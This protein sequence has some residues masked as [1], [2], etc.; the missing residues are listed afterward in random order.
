MSKK[1]NL[2]F[3]F[4]DQQRF[5]TLACYGNDFIKMPN[6]NKLAEQSYV[7][8]N[9]YVTQ[10]VCTPSR[11]SIMTGL[12]PHT[13]GCVKNNVFM[14]EETRTIA[15]MLD[16]DYISAYM[17][18]WH[19]GNERTP[20]HGFDK[21]VSTEDAYIG[22][23][24]GEP[25]IS[26]NYTKFVTANGFTPDTNEPEGL[27]RLARTTSALL[28]EKFTKAMF[29]AYEAS[30]FIEENKD[31]P[32]CLYLN[33]LEPHTPFFSSTHGMYDPDDLP[34]PDHFMESPDEN[35]ALVKQL[36]SRY[37]MNS[38]LR[39]YDFRQE[40]GWKNARAAYYSL[41][42]L[43]DKSVGEIL[44][45]L[46]DCGLEENTIV[47]FTSDH[48]CMQGDHAVA[49]KTLMYE[50]CEKVPM[51]I[52]VP[53]LN[54]E[55]KRLQGSMSQVDLVPT[56]L[57]LMGQVVPEYLEGDSLKPVLEGEKDLFDN[58]VFIEWNG[59]NGRQFLNAGKKGTHALGD[60]EDEAD[61]VKKILGDISMEEAEKIAAGPWRSIISSD[62]WK[63]NLSC[64]DKCE[65]FDLNNDPAELKNLY[66]EPEQ[67]ER[68]AELR[69]RI[70]KWQ[71]RTQDTCPL[72]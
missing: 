60:S 25:E 33:Y 32:F 64:D 40:A 22:V 62:R 42:T 29:T 50:E 13:N 53:W 47:V 6:L 7:F 26:S 66:D 57:E 38:T 14:K 68:I 37:Y 54:K 36:N 52:K 8:E 24:E 27:H 20:Q 1:P 56:L 23:P 46:Q 70:I 39:H 4:T 12:Y 59:A 44:Q 67:Q 11:S 10:P 19:L 31:K 15:E 5:D 49:M 35:Q 51:L 72:P 63:M 16:S 69:A 30:K 43:V 2:L 21:W 41:C 48:G 58:D 9:A 61:P 34:L 18:K 28:P 3:I 17:G 45:T 65:L 55:E 71:E